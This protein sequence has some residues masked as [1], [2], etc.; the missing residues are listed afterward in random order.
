MTFC[1]FCAIVD[2]VIPSWVI[3]R[4]SEVICFLPRRGETYGHTIIA[5][6]SHIQDI[7]SANSQQLAAIMH[8]AKLLAEHYK[9]VLGATGINLLHAS[10]ID[11]QQSVSHFHLHLIPR[12][13]N[14]GI[15]VWPVLN[16]PA[17]DNDQLLAKL[18]M[19]RPDD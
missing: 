16:Q 12:F 3:H 6:I 15:N 1:P 18:I 7:Y 11:A 10:G 5:T 2:G 13:A 9:A 8:E 14:D 17:S 19:R 4:T